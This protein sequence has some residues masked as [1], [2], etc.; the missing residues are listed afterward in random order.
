MLFLYIATILLPGKWLLRISVSTWLPYSRLGDAPSPLRLLV[1]VQE[2]LMAKMLLA[3][4]FPL[5]S[6]L[7]LQLW[8]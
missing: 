3:G 2:W 8:L 5:P 7:V 4:P 6:P 1:T